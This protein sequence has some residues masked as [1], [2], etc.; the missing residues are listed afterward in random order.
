MASWPARSATASS[1]SPVRP[2]TSRTPRTGGRTPPTPMARRS[3]ASRAPY[4]ESTRSAELGVNWQ[5]PAGDWDMELVGLATRRK[6]ASAVT[7]THFDAAGAQDSATTQHVDQD[8]GES[9]VRGTFRRGF[10]AARL[11]TGGEIAI[12]TLDGS[13][14]LSVDAGAGPTPVNVPNA[15]LSV[16]ENRAEGFVSYATPLDENWSFDTRL[17]AETSRLQFTG[18]TEQSVSLTYRQTAGAVHAPIRTSPAAV[19]R[20]PRCGPA[21]LHRL[22]DHLAARRQCRQGRQSGSPAADRLVARSRRR[23]CAFPGDAALRVRALQAISRRRGGPDSGRSARR[24]V[25]TRP[26]ISARAR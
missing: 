2:N 1:A 11:E 19:S 15:N 6:Y 21:R 3:T 10:G 18:D 22:R 5:R 14:D 26:A 17:A 9:I 23:I 8:S 4:D 24:A 25:Q 13:S 20:L 12:N 16:K 7:S